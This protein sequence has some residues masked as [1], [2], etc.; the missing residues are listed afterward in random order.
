[1]TEITAFFGQLAS[2]KELENPT[3]TVSVY[4]NDRPGSGRTRY[5]R[6]VETEELSP[7][8]LLELQETLSPSAEL[9]VNSL[10]KSKGNAYHLALIDFQYQELDDY[11]SQTI[12]D[13]K[14]QYPA[15]LYLFR[16]G[17]SFHGYQDMVLTE[18]AWRSYLGSLLLLNRPGHRE[19]LVDSR[20]VG[21]ALMQGFAALRLTNNT[22][23]Y[24]QL[25]A[26]IKIL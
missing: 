7:A 13:F 4:E 14:K 22:R 26:L 19:E 20:W 15:L 25:P 9:A 18:S 12:A 11:F 1:M 17:R 23:S 8:F 2:I 16:S 24:L 10:I 21:H 3:F 5:R 6:L